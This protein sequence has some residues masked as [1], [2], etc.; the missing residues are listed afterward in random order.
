MELEW[1][2]SR[3][4]LDLQASQ[5]THG[6]TPLLQ[7]SQMVGVT[8]KVMGTPFTWTTVVEY[9]YASSTLKQ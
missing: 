2:E 9:L 3:Q 8:P 7:L 5:K 1:V 4:I 6:N